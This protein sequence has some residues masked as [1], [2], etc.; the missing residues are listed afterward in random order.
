MLSILLFSVSNA[1]AQSIVYYPFNSLLALST[2]PD[3]KL[4]LDVK[5]QTNSYF[6]SLSSEIS[7]EFNLN[8]NPKATFYVG[9]G[10]KLNYLNVF[11]GN[12]ILDGYFFNSG[13]RTSPFEKQKKV[14]IIFELSPFAGRNFD[15]GLLRSYFG[16]GYNFSR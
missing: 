14:Q 1:F 3:K 2:N 5:L 4:W 12:K 13:V 6:S 16:V 8:N 10:M 15:I 7:P 9:L 11:Q